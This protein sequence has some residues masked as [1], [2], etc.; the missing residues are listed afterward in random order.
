M[1][2]LGVEVTAEIF[3]YEGD[4]VLLQVS[5]RKTKDIILAKMIDYV[6]AISISYYSINQTLQSIST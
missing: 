2:D 1:T 4:F 6:L 3:S 5:I